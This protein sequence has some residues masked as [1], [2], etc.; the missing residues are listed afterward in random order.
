MSTAEKTQNGDMVRVKAR[1]ATEFLALQI[2]KPVALQH[3][4][5]YVGNVLRVIIDRDMDVRQFAMLFSIT[6]ALGAD[7]GP[8]E[9]GPGAK[10]M[11][12]SGSGD[13]GADQLRLQLVFNSLNAEQK[14][15][16]D[17]SFS[18]YSRA[19][20]GDDQI[21]L[22]T[23]EG[24]EILNKSIPSDI[25]VLFIDYLP[26]FSLT[27]TMGPSKREKL[28]ALFRVFSKRNL[29]IVI[30][31]LETKQRTMRDE[32]RAR[33]TIYLTHDATAPTEF[34]GGHLLLR[35]RFDDFDSMPKR[36]SFW[37]TNI[38]GEFS[39]GFAV[40]DDEDLDAPR[41]TKRLERLIKVDRM[42]KE[43]KSQKTIAEKLGVDPA[44]ICRDFKEI[45]KNEA[46][47][48]RPKGKG[49]HAHL[50]QQGIAP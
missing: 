9:K 42:R 48:A 41:L 2:P 36:V 3:G 20:E 10:V 30:F 44:T 13:K 47:A 29:T 11:Y 8:F 19:A 45:D 33:N 6:V 22:N 34:G 39:Y 25:E 14:A 18:V 43:G 46:M 23:D 24:R 5:L 31:D 32:E 1:S 15:K 17:R 4:L 49:P 16:L 27:E 35:S 38:D 37:Y 50:K 28:D 12:F 26:A 40:P 21:D 7:L